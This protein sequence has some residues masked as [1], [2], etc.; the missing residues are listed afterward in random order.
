MSDQ[1]TVKDI[2][3]E[4]WEAWQDDKITQFFLKDLI[5][6]RDSV[7]EAYDNIDIVEKTAEQ[8]GARVIYL[9]A[10][11]RATNST[12]DYINETPIEAEEDA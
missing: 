8:I 1:D 7:K 4:E 5:A 6:D 3:L 9:R 10:Y 2:T 12:I 11:L